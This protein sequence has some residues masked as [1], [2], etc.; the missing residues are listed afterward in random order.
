MR[1]NLLHF[2]NVLSDIKNRIFTL[3]NMSFSIYSQLQIKNTCF[4]RMKHVPLLAKF[5][6]KTRDLS[7][8]LSNAFVC[9]QTFTLYYSKI[10]W[11][12]NNQVS[13]MTMFL[14]SYFKIDVECFISFFHHLNIRYISLIYIQ[15]FCDY[16]KIIQRS[17]F[18]LMIYYLEG[19]LRNI[20]LFKYVF[21][22]AKKYYFGTKHICLKRFIF[23]FGLD[24]QR[25]RPNLRNS[26]SRNACL[27]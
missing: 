15:R 27:W 10:F 19:S 13:N 6:T 24:H 3:I 5:L 22:W 9:S 17:F 14:R 11:E 12:I 16:K 2:F 21:L 25:S 20:S 18:D 23:W 8:L 7:L 1:I 26:S 4:G